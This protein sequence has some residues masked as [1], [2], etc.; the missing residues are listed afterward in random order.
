MTVQSK[1][2]A[3][4]YIVTVHEATDLTNA[5]D[6]DPYFVLRYGNRDLKTSTKGAAKQCTWNE[7]FE[8]EEQAGGG[9]ILE[10]FGFYKGGMYMEFFGKASILLSESFDGSVE[11]V[12]PSKFGSSTN[13]SV[14]ISLQKIDPNGNQLTKKKQNPFECW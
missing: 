2:E 4:K 11:L 3:T 12:D 10:I 6:N 1:E 14:K 13:P 8:F 7:V 5:P 9:N